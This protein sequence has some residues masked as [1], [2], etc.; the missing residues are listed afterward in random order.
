MKLDDL[1]LK[2]NINCIETAQ[3]LK[4]QVTNALFLNPYLNWY[5]F[6]E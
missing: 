5:I 6:N 3:C 2:T 1:M 4:R